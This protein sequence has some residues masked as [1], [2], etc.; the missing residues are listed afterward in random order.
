MLF[1]ILSGWEH[2]LMSYH[3]IKSKDEQMLYLRSFKIAADILN[4][5]TF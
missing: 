2:F 1:D 3:F 5:E 4:K